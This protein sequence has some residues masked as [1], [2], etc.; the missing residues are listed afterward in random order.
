MRVHLDCI[1]CFQRQALCAARF[2]TDDEKV[3]ERI[4][5]AVIDKLQA[6]DWEKSP[7]EI[8]HKVHEIVRKESGED[9]PYKDVKK[10]YN[11]IALNMYH[12]LQKIVNDS[13]T[14]LQTAVR[15]AIAGNIIDFGAKTDFDLRK[16]MAIVLKKEFKIYHFS[17]FVKN[18]EKAQ[19]IVF[20]GDNAGEILFDRI[21][22]E[23]IQDRYNIENI[24][25][26][27]KGA[28]IIND[29]TYED[30][31]YVGLNKLKGL[32]F[33][34]VGVGIPGSGMARTSKEFRDILKKSDMVISKGQG[35]FE[36]LS[37]IKGI[38]FLLMAKCPVVAD[39]L[40]VKVDDIVLTGGKL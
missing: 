8:A 21:L 15:L 28:P 4:M 35:N 38:F 37:E 30:A 16:T 29:A 18:L 40:N 31:E 11:D 12:E 33:I 24:L 34:K 13:A 2:V 3:Q 10:Q 17:E 6:M 27:V 22:I 14:P 9:D 36:A 39:H 23:T 5:R 32:E 7:P 26:A 1:P 25:F 19:N 20:L